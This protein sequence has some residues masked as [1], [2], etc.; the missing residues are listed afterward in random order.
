V[1]RQAISCDICGSE[2]RQTNHWFVA[3]DQGGELRVAGW[4]SRNRLRPGS[5]HLCGQ[6]CLHKL[7]DEFMAKAISGR[8]QAGADELEVSDRLADR[9]SSREVASGGY[10]AAGP[11]YDD[12]ES[13]A[14]LIKPHQLHR[15]PCRFALTPSLSPR[16]AVLRLH[17]SRRS[18]ARVPAR[19][20]NRSARLLP[21][22][23]PRP[24][25]RLASGVLRPGTG[26][27]IANSATATRASPSGVEP[28]PENS[29]EVRRFQTVN[30]G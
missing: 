9:G 3:Y 21:L 6:T 12:G 29:S 25:F 23:T 17:P 13:S 14:R 20:L 16:L 15:G 28:V 1:I 7:V 11:L 26:S 2:K 24:A 4:S 8:A 5:K 30:F 19:L 22:K 18:L 27:A 10:I